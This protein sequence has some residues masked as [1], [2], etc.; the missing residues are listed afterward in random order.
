[1]NVNIICNHIFTA[2]NQVMIDMDYADADQL[3][4]LQVL[5]LITVLP[6]V[7]DLYVSECIWGIHL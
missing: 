2:W 7:E 4:M 1:M 3:K 6:A 5:A